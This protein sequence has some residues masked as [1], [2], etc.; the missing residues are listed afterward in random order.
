MIRVRRFGIAVSAMAVA[1]AAPVTVGAQEAVTER[2]I[3]A[4]HARQGVASDGQSIYAVDN[5]VITRISLADGT[6][7]GE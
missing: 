1:L 6:Q 7:T 4:E 3:K 5:N 2:V